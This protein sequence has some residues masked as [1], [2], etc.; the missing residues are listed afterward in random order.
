MRYLFKLLFIACFLAS[1]ATNNFTKHRVAENIADKAGFSKKLVRGGQFWLTT[2]QKISDPSKPFVI[3]IEGDG[4]AFIKR[5]RI[6]EDPTPRTPVLITL[7]TMDPRPNVIYLA[8][9]CQYTP[10]E[11]N[12]VCNYSYWTDKRMSEDSV[13]ALNEAVINVAGRNPVDLIGFSGGGGIA[14]L[15]GARN[16][17]VRS[18]LTIAGN[19]DHEE[20]NKYHKVRPM[21]GSLN[22]IDYANRVKH[23]P[24]LHISGG[25]DKVVPSFIADNFVKKMGN[26]KCARREII[27]DASHS[28]NWDKEW[29]YIISSPIKCHN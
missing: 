8:R 6:S 12:K 7:A 25:H 17:Q 22:P 15:I 27:S 3:Y 16:N 14:V 11:V 4:E 13:A 24:Q 20:F 29:A 10:M 23:I 9:P 26:S 19:L 5:Y 21:I 2:Y 28:K 18:I 1:C